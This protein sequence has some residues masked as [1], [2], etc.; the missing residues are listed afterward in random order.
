MGATSNNYLISEP[1]LGTNLTVVAGENSFKIATGKYNLTLYLSQGI[2]VVEKW[3]E[4]TPV[5]R[6]DVNAD[7]VISIEDVTVLIDYLLDK[8]VSIN[9]DN[10]DCDLDGFVGIE[11]APILIDYLLSKQW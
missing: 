2:L 1:R 7:G 4:P 3:T 9:P 6:G 5:V 10:A 11:D 8:T